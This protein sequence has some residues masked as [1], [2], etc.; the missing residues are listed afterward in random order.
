MALICP[1]VQDEFRR[2]RERE[3][4]RERETLLV[5]TPRREEDGA[6]KR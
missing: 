2:V 6:R 5:L 1:A 4:E 3:K